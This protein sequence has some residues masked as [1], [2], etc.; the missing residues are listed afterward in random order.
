MNIVWHIWLADKFLL[1]LEKTLQIFQGY[2]FA[3]WSATELNFL[4][5]LS[6]NSDELAMLNFLLES[7]YDILN[8]LSH[9]QIN[10]F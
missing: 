9:N 5:Y 10:W 1:G 2:P 4:G 7:N 8:R 6:K 3:A